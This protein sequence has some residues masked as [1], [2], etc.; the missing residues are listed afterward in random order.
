MAPS[1]A[2]KARARLRKAFPGVHVDS[3]IE[4]EA[5]S[6]AAPGNE[7]EEEAS[8]T[9]KKDA[10]SGWATTTLTYTPMDLST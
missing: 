3:D 6:S 10:E 7:E 1:A 5:S 9:A 8:M 2:S 4:S